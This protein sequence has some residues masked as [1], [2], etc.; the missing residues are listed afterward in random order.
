MRRER[1][2]LRRQAQAK[3]LL[4][5][6]FSGTRLEPSVVTRSCSST[7]LKSLAPLDPVSAPY[8]I[9]CDSTCDCVHEPGARRMDN[10]GQGAVMN[11]VEI[12]S[13]LALLADPSVTGV[14]G[15]LHM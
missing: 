5:Q 7:L 1:V 13:P 12:P 6:K 15:Q 10:S 11:G 8:V 14:S 3:Q 4:G 9:R 2:K